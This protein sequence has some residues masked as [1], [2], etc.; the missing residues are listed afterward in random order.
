MKYHRD[1]SSCCYLRSPCPNNDCLKEC[2][3]FVVVGLYCCPENRYRGLQLK[4][5]SERIRRGEGEGKNMWWG[6]KR[7]KNPTKRFGKESVI[8]EGNSGTRTRER[9]CQQHACSREESEMSEN[10]FR[11]IPRSSLCSRGNTHK[12]FVRMEVGVQGISAVISRANRRVHRSG[13]HLSV[14]GM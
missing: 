1:W 6:G 14:V 5:M 12:A 7:G 2:R 8:I 3:E 10:P 9:Q 4:R 13:W 11:G